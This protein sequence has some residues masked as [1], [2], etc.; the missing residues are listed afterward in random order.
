MSATGRGGD[1]GGIAMTNITK[2]ADPGGIPA[3]VKGRRRTR[4]AAALVGG[5]VLVMGAAFAASGCSSNGGASVPKG[6]AVEQVRQGDAGL[7][8][9]APTVKSGKVAF[10]IKNQGTIGH[11]LV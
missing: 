7:S 1:I 6:A 2:E 5:A 4:P 8:L 9:S 10:E 11:E 3:A